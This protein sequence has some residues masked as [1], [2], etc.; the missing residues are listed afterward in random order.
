MSRYG[1]P[2][3]RADY[4]AYRARR[5]EQLAA[6]GLPP[7]HERR[8]RAPAPRLALGQG[9]RRRH[10]AVLRAGG[11]PGHHDL[12]LQLNRRGEALRSNLDLI[13]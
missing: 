1:H 12:R 6:A 13:K 2:R 10:A 3:P 4:A 7:R 9:R 11:R 8:R 5:A